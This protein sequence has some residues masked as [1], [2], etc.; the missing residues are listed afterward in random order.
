LIRSLTEVKACRSVAGVG[1]D[2]AQLRP[3]ERLDDRL[4]AV[5][6]RGAR[7]MITLC[8]DSGPQPLTSR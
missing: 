3:H 8:Y 2:P 1:D 4:A 6:W 7:P 5:L